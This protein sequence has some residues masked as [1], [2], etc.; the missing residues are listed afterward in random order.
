MARPP[1]VGTVHERRLEVRPRQVPLQTPF[2][3][4]ARQQRSCMDLLSFPFRVVINVVSRRNEYPFCSSMRCQRASF[5][6]PMENPLF[7]FV[8]SF[9]SI[10]RLLPLVKPSKTSPQTDVCSDASGSGT[11]LFA[12]TQ[13]FNDGAVSFD[14]LLHEV[15]QKAA[16]LTNHFQ[17][18]AT[19]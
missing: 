6:Y 17:K 12:K 10:E 3:S 13:S 2:P 15:I 19:E 1:H 7:S 14:I 5:L 16:A 8:A 11:K 18:T 9:L 4:K